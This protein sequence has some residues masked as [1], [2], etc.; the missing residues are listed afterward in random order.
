[1]WDPQ[2]GGSYTGGFVW[3]ADVVAAGTA[4]SNGR[5]I[6]Y[7]DTYPSL[8][9][10]QTEGIEATAAHEYQHL[11]HVAYDPGEQTFVNEGLSEWAEVANGYF[12]REITYLGEASEHNTALF[13]WRRDD[14]NLVLNDY[15]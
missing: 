9:N 6:L 3:Y 1:G 12:T 11:I 5:D 13:T 2:T 4:N 8:R 10:G 7:V 14:G 15:Q